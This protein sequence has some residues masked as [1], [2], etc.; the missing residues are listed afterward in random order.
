MLRMSMDTG[1]S[2]SHGE[3][4]PKERGALRLV[5]TFFAR[6]SDEVSF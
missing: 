4:V 2:L 5:E 1:T 3:G 6:Y